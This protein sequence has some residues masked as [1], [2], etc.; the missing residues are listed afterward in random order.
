MKN[1]RLR[2]KL[3][4]ALA[5]MTAVV[6]VAAGCDLDTTNP[7]EP[8]RDRALARG[9]DVQS[10]VQSAYVNYFNNAQEYE[11]GCALSVMADHHTSSWGN[12]GMRQSGSEPRAPWPNDPSFTYA[13][14]N[15]E[16][17]FE[18]YAAAVS[19][20]DGIRALEAGVTPPE[21]E[22]VRAFSRFIQGLSHGFIA[23]MF[24]QGFIVDENT[25]PQASQEL[26]P[27]R[28]VNQ[29]AIAF[30]QQARDIAQAGDFT[31][32]GDWMK[33]GELTTDQFVRIINSYMARFMTNWPRTPA[34]AQD[35]DWSAVMGLIDAGIQE[36]VVASVGGTGEG[37]WSGI[38][39]LC[40]T[41]SI[42]G[43]T[44]LRQVGPADTSGAYQDWLATPVDDRQP[45]FVQ[46]PDE[47]LPA[48]Q[49]DGDR[50]LYVSYFDAIFFRP[51]RGTYHF[52]NYLDHRYEDYAFSCNFCWFG[53]IPEMTV[54]EMDLLKAEA[55]LMTGDSAAAAELI[56]RTRT[57]NGGLPAVTKDGVPQSQSCVPQT[58]DGAC[59][60]IWLALQYEKGL[61]AF[62]V[63][64][65]L[66][67]TDDRRWG[68][69]VSGTALHFPVPGAELETLQMEI[70]TF[71]GEEGDAAP[72]VSPTN[73]ETGYA[74]ERVGYDLDALE[75][76]R[77]RDLEQLRDL[78]R[79]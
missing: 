40:S 58:D 1:P 12:F 32:P 7:N 65:G 26:R 48:E 51:E 44:D 57:A 52:S 78:S 16:P 55:H 14:T 30:L 71:G 75:R 70:Y 62:Q 38:K 63:S 76:M 29:A 34:E 59:G 2:R 43:R 36:D 28:E 22:R 74:L 10:L 19:A 64:S 61:E 77:E 27:Y 69:L 72:S 9:E 45:F 8:D 33:T 60:D 25:D 67:Y 5:G 35:V 18:L 24:D 37:F 53:N 66:A 41:W 13:G 31:I 20:S 50:G 73:D 49:V 79:Q 54:T 6:L 4:K 56:N 17:W 68:E 46:T 23:S 11:P 21:P 15:E 47:R 42:W 39:T 3:T